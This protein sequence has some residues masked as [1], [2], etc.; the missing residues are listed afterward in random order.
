MTTIESGHGQPVHEQFVEGFGTFR[1]IPVDPA[2]DAA[3]LHAWVSEDRA[4]FWGMRETTVEDVREIYAHLDSL[5]TH[6]AF[7]VHRDGEPV[8]LFQT[9]EPEADRVSECYEVE[10]GDLGVHL[11][12]APTAAPERGFSTALVTV[13]KTY[14]LTGRT[15]L[16]AEPDAANEKAVGLLARNGFEA[17]PEVVLPEIVLPEVHLEEKR[18]R[19]LFLTR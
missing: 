13:L 16:V 5:T 18:A 10:P 4:R 3:L 9:Y 14:A 8:A 6:H 11:L 15:R 17:G 2:R 12:I 19:L 7:M 1:V